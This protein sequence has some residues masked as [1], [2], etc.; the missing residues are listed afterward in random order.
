V[1]HLVGTVTDRRGG[2][3]RAPGRGCGVSD[4]GDERN[5]QV[6]DRLRQSAAEVTLGEGDQKSITVN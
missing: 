5:P 2:L 3:V 1:T 6:L 4:T